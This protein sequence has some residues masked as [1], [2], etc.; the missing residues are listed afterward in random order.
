MPLYEI[1]LEQ[2][3]FGQQCINRWNYQSGAIPEG[4]SGAY[5]AIVAM[6]FIED[7]D[8]P[9]FDATTIAGLLQPSQHS[10][11]IYVQVIAKNL[12]SVT[13]FY[14]YAFPP[15][16]IGGNAGGE[17]LSPTMAYGFASNRTRS[18]IRRAQKRFVG[19]AE[20][21]VISGGGFTTAAADS[22]QALG[23]RMAT[24]NTATVDGDTSTFTPYV[25]GRQKYVVTESGKDAYRYY[26]TEAEQLE[27]IAP[28]TAFDFKDN[29][30]TQTSR[31]Y[32]RGA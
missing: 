22:L 30:R 12:Y 14:T 26:P 23:D 18:D 19:V 16:T 8:T 29:V 3:Y 32:G 5:L 20:N 25:F 28:I 10:S 17:G 24:I 21:V 13:D 15:G 6:G 31:Q 9:A 2:Q 7:D 11:V 27:H 1:T 4:Q